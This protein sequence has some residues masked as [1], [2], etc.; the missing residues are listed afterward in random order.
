MEDLVSPDGLD[1]VTLCFSSGDTLV[2]SCLLLGA[3]SPL[4]R[5]LLLPREI[6]Q[7]K[8][9]LPDFNQATMAKILNFMHTGEVN[10]ERK[11][12]WEFVQYCQYFG[13]KVFE[14]V[15][16]SPNGDIRVEGLKP[17]LKVVGGQIKQEVEE[18]E[19]NIQH[20]ETLQE[21]YDNYLDQTVN[22]MPV[23]TVL[24]I[25]E[26]TKKVK[27]KRKIPKNRHFGCSNCDYKTPWQGDLKKHIYAHHFGIRHKCEQCPAEFVHKRGL[28]VHI[29]SSHEGVIY[30][31]T[32]CDY[33]AIR[34]S[35]LKAHVGSKHEGV[36][37]QCKHCPEKFMYNSTLKKH[38]GAKHLAIK[39][40]CEY[41]PK[42][43]ERQ[44]NAKNHTERVHYKK[45]YKCDQMA[46]GYPCAYMS[47]VKERVKYHKQSFH[48]KEKF[49]CK[50]CDYEGDT[51]SK[52][53]KHRSK[54]H[55]KANLCNVCNVQYSHKYQ[56]KVHIN[57]K[58]NIF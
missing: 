41:C 7:T 52:Y 53:K 9:M 33:N 23:E 34:E 24:K 47:A 35:S 46:L 26:E 21:E 54:T 48:Y 3:S 40:E 16:C 8:V 50:D 58:H 32:V 17:S 12:T 28:K 11:D 4:L 15:E 18:E 51:F 25:T 42:I 45:R 10:L 55:A 6:S 20:E 22:I 43:F 5:D 39:F 31:C 38:V 49:Y 27:K 56:L 13:L 29:L 36:R 19:E 57:S 44:D 37:Y 30:P 14:E 2:S 1:C